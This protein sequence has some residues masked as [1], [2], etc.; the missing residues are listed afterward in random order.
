[1]LW[2]CAENILLQPGTLAPDVPFSR[3]NVVK[4]QPPR[5]DFKKFYEDKQGKKPTQEL[6]V[7]YQLLKAELEEHRPN[8]AVAVGNEALKALCGVSGIHNYRGSVLASTLVPGLKVIPIIHPS[9]FFKGEW[10]YFYITRFDMERI[11]KEMEFPE[12]IRRPYNAFVSPTLS[13]VMDFFHRIPDGARWTLD[14]ETRGSTLS[15]FGIAY[16]GNEVQ[17][18]AICIPLQTTTGPYWGE[19]EELAIWRAL[20]GLCFRNPHFVNQNV[21]F[22]IEHL[23]DYGVEP[24]IEHDTMLMQRCCYPEFPA[25]LEFITSIYTDMPYYKSEGKEEFKGKRNDQDLWYYNTKDVVAPLWASYALEQELKE[26]SMAQTYDTYKKLLPVALEMQRTRLPINAANKDTL[27]VLLT[28]EINKVHDALTLQIGREINVGSWQQ[29]GKLLYE[30]MGM[31]VKRKRGSFTPTTDENAIRELRTE[32]PPHYDLLTKIIQERHLRKRKSNYIDFTPDADGH[33]PSMAQCLGTETFRWSF[34]QSPKRRGFNVHTPPKVMRWMVE[35]PPGRVFIQPD[36]SQAEARYVAWKAGCERLIDLFVTPGT[37]IHIENGRRI[38]K[39]MVEKDTEEYDLVKAMQHAANYLVGARRLAAET[40]I[41][42][43]QALEVLS[44]YYQLYPE[45]QNWHHW[46]KTE[47]MRSGT[48]VN[49]HGVRRIFYEFRGHVEN[50]GKVS[51][52]AWKDAIAW[53]PQSSVPYVINVATLKARDNHPEIWFHQNGHDSFLASIPDDRI[54]SLAPRLTSYLQYDMDI[55]GI[56]GKVRRL[57]IP[58][59]MQYGYNWY[60]MA[61]YCEG[62]ASRRHWDEWVEGSSKATQE[63]LTKRLYGIF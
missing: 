9:A 21:A 4:Y 38:L 57:T 62:H 44:G 59:D 23:L 12:I 27:D 24:T 42:L 17:P 2:R 52:D 18:R 46:I 10:R 11:A 60:L 5:N 8:L 22:D 7:Y 49:C 26:Q 32:Y 31:K 53:E 55:L 35:P 56:D 45:I 13:H 20:D 43:L 37:N 36:L 61:P 47:I 41:S 29:V 15:C 14:V 1:M 58:A 19:E 30:E 16:Q 48:L 39:K 40:G 63:S 25:K 54:D 51:K 6:L 3:S 34:A 50:T 28:G 33:I